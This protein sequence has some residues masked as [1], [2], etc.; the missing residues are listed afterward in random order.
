MRSKVLTSALL[1]VVATALPA[2]SAADTVLLD[3]RSVGKVCQVVGEFDRERAA[4]TLNQTETRARF[5]GTDL[6]ASFEHEGRLVVAFGDTH[7]SHGMIRPRDADSIAFSDTRHGEDC[8][9]LEFVRDQDG[10][11][12]PITIP[13][14]Y[15]GAFAVPSGGFSLNGRMYLLATS[16]VPGRGPSNRSVFARSD[17]DGWTFRRLFDLSQER[18]VHV[19]P[20]LVKGGAVK[21]APDPAAPGVFYFGTS[22][23]RR[24]SPF[25]A[26]TPQAA[27]ED[28]QALRYFAGVDPATGAPRWSENEADSAPLFEQPCMGEFS[29]GWNAHLSK[30][31]L[32][33]TCGGPRARTEIRTAESPWGP[34]S[35]PQALFDPNLDR[36]GCGFVNRPTPPIIAAGIGPACPIVSDPHT[37]GVLGESY[38]PYLIDRLTRSDYPFTSTIYFLMSTWNPYTV[39]LMRATLVQVDETPTGALPAAG[40]SQAR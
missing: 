3:Q 8:L 34:W 7:P 29:A 12:R 37:P 6:G 11:F 35:S 23:F 31:L 21:D 40:G 26:W 1:C 15:A 4:P 30:W 22:E 17:D 27:V 18:F 13:G 32:L 24:S 38:G 9:Q 14:I 39:V 19:S 28:P 36:E 25:L 16:D 5:W 20:V 2:P 10:G 33:Y